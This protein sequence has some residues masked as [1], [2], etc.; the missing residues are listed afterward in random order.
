MA[1]P[2][3][4]SIGLMSPEGTNSSKSIRIELRM[5]DPRLS[6]AACIAEGGI[7]PFAAD[8]MRLCGRLPDAFGWQPHT[9]FTSVA[10]HLGSNVPVSKARHPWPQTRPCCRRYTSSAARPSPQPRDAPLVR[11]AHPACRPSSRSE[12]TRAADGRPGL[13]SRLARSLEAPV[14]D[15]LQREQ[16]AGLLRAC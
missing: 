8:A 10:R 13:A 15:Q 4:G 6:A 3:L 14:P 2:E 7:Q 5:C 11:R 16:S 12:E 9:S 1:W